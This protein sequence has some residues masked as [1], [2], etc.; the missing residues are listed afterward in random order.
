M[1][2]L[3]EQNVSKNTRLAKIL[4]FLGY[5]VTV[6]DVPVGERPYLEVSAYGFPKRVGEITKKNGVVHVSGGKQSKPNDLTF[7]LIKA[8]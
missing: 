2:L 6:V 4:R 5:F 7:K 1:A 3:I 8:E